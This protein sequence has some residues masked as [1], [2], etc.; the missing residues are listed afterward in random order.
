MAVDHVMSDGMVMDDA[1]ATGR[2]GTGD[3][4]DQGGGRSGRG[5]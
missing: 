4:G 1:A 2:R 5:Q 3:D